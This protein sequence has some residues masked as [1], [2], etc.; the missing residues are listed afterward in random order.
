MLKEFKIISNDFNTF[1]ES[2]CDCTQL[3]EGLSTKNI[4]QTIPGEWLQISRRVT[5]SNRRYSH[6]LYCTYCRCITSNSSENADLE[7]AIEAT[8]KFCF[9]P[10]TKKLERELNAK[11]FFKD[12]YLRETNVLK[13]SV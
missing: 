10:L 8:N 7:K 6:I 2:S 11:H 12:E 1:E 3:A 9:K 13:L 5:T 4:Q